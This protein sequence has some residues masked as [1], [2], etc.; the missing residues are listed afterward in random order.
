[1]LFDEAYK[2][3][4]RFL[5]DEGVYKRAM[6]IHSL[7]GEFN[8]HSIKK[9]L[10][11]VRPSQWIQNSMAFYQWC[12][13]PEGETFWWPISILWQIKCLQQEIIIFNE[14]ESKDT[15]SQEVMGSVKSYSEWA[16]YQGIT[17]KRHNVI[18]KY[19][20]EHNII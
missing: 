1:M 16:V 3:Y 20:K 10:S 13:T 4:K 6:E 9:K 8:E 7:K 19:K 5:K 2:A 11:M 14:Y 17:G 15:L 18:T 12:Y